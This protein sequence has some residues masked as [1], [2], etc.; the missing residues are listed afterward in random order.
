MDKGDKIMEKMN[1]EKS[2]AF[3]RDIYLLGQ[4][5]DGIYYWLEAPNWD[6]GWYWGFGYIETYTNN[7]SPSHSK[8][9]SSHQHADNFINWWMTWNNNKYILKKTTFTEKEGWELTE[10]FER[11]YMFSKIAEYYHRGGA[12]FTNLD[13]DKKD[14]KECDR[15]NKEEIPYI[16]KRILDILTPKKGGTK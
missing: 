10:L 16:T 15:I 4:D 13:D 8:D 11:F 1:K 7:I 14:Q 6:C 9:I 12:G 3:G 5:E 2:F